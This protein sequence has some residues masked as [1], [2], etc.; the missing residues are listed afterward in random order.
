MEPIRQPLDSIAR[1]ILHTLPP[2]ERVMAA[3]PLVCGSRVAANAKAVGFEGATL[4]VVVADPVWRSE[5]APLGPRHAVRLQ[6]LTG[7][8]VADI[9]FAGR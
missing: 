2:A 5:L 4:R 7:V 8:P 1:D 9:L 6:Q 3:W